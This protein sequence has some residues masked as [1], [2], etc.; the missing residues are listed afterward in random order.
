VDKAWWHGL[1]DPALDALEERLDKDNPSLAAIL[2]KH[3]LATAALR[4]SKAAQMP[5]V[6]QHVDTQPAIG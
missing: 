6:I 3:R 5:D 1:N 4:Q 2:A